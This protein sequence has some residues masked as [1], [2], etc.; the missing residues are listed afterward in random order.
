MNGFPGGRGADGSMFCPENR[1]QED[2][3]GFP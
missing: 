1:N 3:R 2:I